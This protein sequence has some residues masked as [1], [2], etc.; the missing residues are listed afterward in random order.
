MTSISYTFCSVA[1]QITI[2][3]LLKFT[4]SSVRSGVSHYIFT[5]FLVVLGRVTW[6][7][8]DS[9]TLNMLYRSINQCRYAPI[10]SCLYRYFIPHNISHPLTMCIIVS[11]CLWNNLHKFEPPCF[12]ISAFITL[13]ARV[14]SCAAHIS[15]SFSNHKCAECHHLCPP[16]I[17]TDARLDFFLKHFPCIFMLSNPL[18]CSLLI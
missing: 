4:I 9:H 15:D 5:F 14:C 1:F 18:L 3:V 17:S 8:H 13:V 7:N 2:L 10:L 16:S 6:C 11:L 12:H